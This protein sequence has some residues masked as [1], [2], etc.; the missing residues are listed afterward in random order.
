MVPTSIPPA[1]ISR[2]R[3]LRRGMTDGERRLWSEL[4]EFRRWYGIHVRRQAPIGP[5]V[6]DFVIHEHRLV[7]E[8]DGEHHFLPDRMSRDLRRDEWLASQGYKVLRL[9]TGEL[10]DSFE[11]CIIEILHALGLMENQEGTPT[12]SPTPQGGGGPGRPHD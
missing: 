11:G 1:A 7:I 3:K 4:R 10:S 5:Y 6:A 12:A 9:T 8:V 2:A